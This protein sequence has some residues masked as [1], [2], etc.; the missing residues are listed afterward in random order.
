M[1]KITYHHKGETKEYDLYLPGNNDLCLTSAS[2]SLEEGKAGDLTL[3][4]PYDNTARNALVCLTDE[5]IVYRDSEELFRGRCITKQSDFNLT[6]TLTVEGILTY[7]YDTY[8]PPFNFQGPPMDLLKKVINNHNSFVDAEKQFQIGTVTVEDANNYIARSSESYNRTIDILSDKFVGDSLG[9]YF[10]ARVSGGTRYL[11]YLKTYGTRAEQ[12][13]ELGK[14]I[15]DLAIEIEYS[16]LITAILPLGAKDTQTD[17]SGNQTSKY[18]T[19]ESVNGGDLYIRDQELIKKYGFICECV[20]WQDVTEP[21]NLKTKATAYLAQKSLAI[22]TLTIKAVDLYLASESETPFQLGDMVTVKSTP[23]GIDQYVELS[24]IKLDLLNPANDTLTFGSTGTTLTGN[25]SSNNRNLSEGLNN[26]TVVVGRISSDYINTKTLEAEVA[27]LGYLTAEKADIKY[28]KAEDADIK[29]AN[30][31]FSNIDEA[32]IKKLFSETGIIKDLTIEDGKVTGELVGVTI[33]GDLIEGNTIAADKLVIKGEDGLYYKLN[34][35]ALGETTAK[36][37][38]KY[39]SGL[40]GS[41]LIKKSIVAEKIAVDDLVAFGATIGGVNI[42]DGSIY[43]GVKSSVSN[44][45]TGFYLGKDG[46][47]AFGN[48]KSFMKLFKSGSTWKLAFSGALEAASGTFK[49]AL[50]AAS[51]TFEGT[52]KASGIQFNG[53]SDYMKSSGKVWIA[54]GGA[55]ADN[56]MYMSDNSASKDY[57]YGNIV[58]NYPGLRIAGNII[59]SSNDI[60]YLATHTWDGNAIGFGIGSGGENRGLFD[61]KPNGSNNWIIYRSGNTTYTN[62]TSDSR[63]KED[64]GEIPDEEALAML[65]GIIPKNFVYKDGCEVR[66]I[67]NGFMA[68]NV[69]DVLKENDIGYRPYLLIDEDNYDLYTPEEE[70]TYGLDYSK[71]VPLLLKGWQMHERQISDLKVQIAELKKGLEDGNTD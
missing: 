57:A 32:A 51:G 54:T 22:E 35:N 28:L 59:N 63:C 71:F 21:A 16:D 47:C 69:R 68:Q 55:L 23:H 2:L 10:R 31:D 67:Q 34:V 25:T 65:N 17:S 60:N 15:L 39:Q 7:L 11:D 6:G 56:D 70:V 53:E 41:V 49:G 43:S 50:E 18:V 44:T 58:N 61:Y 62:T 4:V 30:I 8:F 13:V 3:G 12:T 36:A 26:V 38:P 20:E 29:F 37:D 46:Q 64:Q 42:G 19:V 48:S 66:V 1:Y 40:D 14:N 52:V 9:G 24:A 45:T 27:K 5:I 33:K